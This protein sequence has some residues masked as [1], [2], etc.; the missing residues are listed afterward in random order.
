M[1]NQNNKCYKCGQPIQEERWLA[2][3]VLETPIKVRSCLNC[4][5]N[6]YVKGQYLGQS[7][8]SNMLLVSGVYNDRI[9]RDNSNYSE[10]K[11]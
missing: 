10:Y 5:D 3:D 7:G 8:S 4:A 9:V 6:R 1:N 11:E 2:L